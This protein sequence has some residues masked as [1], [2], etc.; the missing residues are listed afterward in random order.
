MYAFGRGLDQDF[1]RARPLL[2]VAAAVQH[3]PS[4]YYIGVFKTYGYGCQ[5]N[6]DQAINWFERAAG[7]DDFRVSAKAAKAAEEL[8][9][10]VDGAHLQNN[11]RYEHYQVASGGVSY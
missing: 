7:L 11:D 8:R 3:A 4:I 6:Y 1:G 9:V 10:A 5:V 2:E